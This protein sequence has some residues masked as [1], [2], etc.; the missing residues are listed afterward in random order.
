MPTRVN[1]I[2]MSAKKRQPG[3]RSHGDQK[4]SRIER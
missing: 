1:L 3:E 2:T 4:A